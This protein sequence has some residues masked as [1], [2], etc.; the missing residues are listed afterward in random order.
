MSTLPKITAKIVIN[1]TNE[2]HDA[3]F[4][5]INQ[6]MATIEHGRAMAEM[7]FGR[8]IVMLPPVFDNNN[9]T[10][11]LAFEDNGAVYMTVNAVRHTV[12]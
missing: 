2:T 4:Q 9:L 7:A 8:R 5:D 12:Q 6:F 1:E 10:L 11:K 3:S